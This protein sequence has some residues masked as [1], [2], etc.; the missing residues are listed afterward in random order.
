MEMIW[1]FVGLFRRS[2]RW[3][4]WKSDG[5]QGRQAYA[6]KQAA[7]WLGLAQRA[8]KEFGLHQDLVDDLKKYA[9]AEEEKLP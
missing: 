3:S 5:S 6:C 7:M 2:C 4:L 8:Q 9:R 1:T